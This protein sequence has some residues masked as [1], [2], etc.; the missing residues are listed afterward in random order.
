M[1]LHNCFERE[2]HRGRYP[3]PPTSSAS[4]FWQLSQLRP[5]GDRTWELSLSIY[6]FRYKNLIFA[7][8]MSDKAKEKIDFL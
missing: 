6:I 3:I 5:A 7:I 4:L 1:F 2:L 8:K